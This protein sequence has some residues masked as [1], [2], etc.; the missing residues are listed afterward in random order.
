MKPQHTPAPWVIKGQ[1]II[2]NEQNGYICTW[3]G[4]K[5]DA[6]LIA[7]APEL[8]KALENLLTAV[9]K[10]TAFIGNPDRPCEKANAAIAKA[11]G[12]RP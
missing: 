2:G 8:M 11:K 4:R 1:D 5:A 9:N 3:S 12:D 7:A 6:H 10:G